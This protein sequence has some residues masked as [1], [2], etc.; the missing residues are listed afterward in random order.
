MTKVPT[1]IQNT[2][3]TAIVIAVS[4]ACGIGAG[5]HLIYCYCKKMLRP[6]EKGNTVY[7]FFSLSGKPLT[8]PEKDVYSMKH[9]YDDGVQPSRIAEK[10]GL[11]PVMVC[12]VINM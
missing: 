7:V 2:P 4:L 3:K 8:L 6:S 12:R 1:F 11:T 5:C 10:F 9:M